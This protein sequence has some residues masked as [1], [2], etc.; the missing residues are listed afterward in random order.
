MALAG[1]GI[2]CSILGIFT[3]RTKENATFAQLLKGLHKG[4]YVASAAD[5][6]GA[7]GLLAFIFIGRDG[8]AG[9][10]TWWGLGLSIVAGLVAGLVIAYATEYY[11]SYEHPPTRRIAQ[12]ALTGPAT[13]II[14]GSRRA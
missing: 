1:L 10:T 2:L 9:L 5:R 13:V 4:V 12:Q 3:V 8:P 11:T 6:R 7:F 14:A